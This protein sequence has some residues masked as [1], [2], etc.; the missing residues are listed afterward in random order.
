MRK[1]TNAVMKLGLMS[2]P[3]RKGR[4]GLTFAAEDKF[5]KVPNSETVC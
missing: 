5:I 2:D 3:L 4:P 1:P